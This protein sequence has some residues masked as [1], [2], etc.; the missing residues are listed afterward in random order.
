MNL[1]K[2]T[3]QFA[4]LRLVQYNQ[5]MCIMQQGSMLETAWNLAYENVCYL[6]LLKLYTSSKGN[7]T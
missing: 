3:F 5:L 1:M 7:C 2:Q 4:T 6:Q